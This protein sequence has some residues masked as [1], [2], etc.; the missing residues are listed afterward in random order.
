M[1][2]LDILKKRGITSESLKQKLSGDPLN[3]T[4]ER[5]LSYIP[6]APN[7]REKIQMLLNR[8]RSR[9]QEGMTRNLAD[10]RVYYALDKAWDKPFEQISPTIVQSLMDSDPNNEE[11]YKAFQS[12]GLAHMINEEQDPKNPGKSVKTLN[13][14]TFF[15]IFVPLVKA[16]VTIRWAKIMN[17][18]RLTPFF[19]YEPF[20]QTSELQTKCDV[21]TDRV[22]VMSNQLGYYDVMKQSVLK[23]LHYSQCFQFIK[24][25][26]YYEEQLKCADE[27]D[28]AM[29]KLNSK[30]EPAA[31]GEEIKVTDKEGLRYHFPHPTRT[32]YDLAHGPYTINYDTGC[33]YMGY[34]RIARYREIWF[35]DFWNKD[36]IALG[37]ADIVAANTLFFTTV[38][39]SCQLKTATYVAPSTPNGEQGAAAI[40]SGPGPMDREKEIAYQYYGTDHLDQGVLVN[41]YFEKLIP[42]QW[43]LGDYDHPVWFRFVMAGD[44]CTV[45]YAAPLPYAPA[46]YYGYDADET[47][48][49]NASMSLEILPFQD[50]FSNMLSQILLTAKQNLANITLVD[51]DT[52][53]E[54]MTA[55]VKNMGERFFRTLNI[56]PFSGKKLARGQNQLDRIAQ[57]IGLPKGNTAELTNVLKTILDVLERVLVM[58]S[59]EVGQA[60][61]H[62]QTREEIRN[63]AQNTSSRLVFTSTPIDIAEAAWKR[64]IYQGLMAYGD[65]DIFVR[66]PSDMPVDQEALKT[67]GFT[68]IDKD[69]LNSKD[70][71]WNV[72]I[73]KKRTAIPLWEIASNRDGEDRSNDEKTAVT[74]ATILDKLLSNPLTAQAIGVDQALD[75][76]NRI[77]YLAGIPRD[78]KFRNA[79]AGADQA[80]PEQQAEAARGELQQVVQTVLGSVNQTLQKELQPLLDETMKNS[81]DI[82]L[83]MPKL[84]ELMT[85]L[86]ANPSDPTNDPSNEI[87]ATGA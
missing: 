10:Y 29:G 85:A 15:N 46:T 71:Y 16:Y 21:I 4:T 27:L 28:V 72:K 75:F 12:W 13:L 17:D 81:K 24:E 78:W 39:S 48:S 36:K 70:K 18:R 68:F 2:D 26:W 50:H 3:R 64:Q 14:P 80:T 38:Y 5:G 77:C 56:F 83:I 69:K 59:N 76:T 22:H 45:L 52:V 60:A 43:G 9:I 32:Y 55:K 30:G 61:S 54:D 53:G 40:G 74:L 63:I 86:N 49:R 65:D 31:L 58:S 47:R 51:T 34:W 41:E 25:E 79:A 84:A 8:I 73:S 82:A 20:K 66:I 44:G 67:M 87:A 35:G 19:K 1:I 62:E 57:S 7:D 6:I 23:M 37:T 42:S 33:E 11:V